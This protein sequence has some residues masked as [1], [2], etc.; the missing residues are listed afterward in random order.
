MNTDNRCGRRVSGAEGEV[1]LGQKQ[2]SFGETPKV[3]GETPV[4]PTERGRSH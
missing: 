2:S 1:D 3:T 4:L